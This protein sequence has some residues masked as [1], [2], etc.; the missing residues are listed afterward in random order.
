M[1][2]LTK[3]VFLG[4]L[5]PSNRPLMF[6][7]ALPSPDDGELTRANHLDALVGLSLACLLRPMDMRADPMLVGF[8]E[9]L[10]TERR[11]VQER[12]QWPS[13]NSA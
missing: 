2:K 1:G 6:C 4:R 11:S 5:G 10:H 8:M 9:W 7:A 12:K 13:E 3:A